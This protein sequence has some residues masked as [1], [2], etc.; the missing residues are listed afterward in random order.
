[1]PQFTGNATVDKNTNIDLL[2]AEIDVV[3]MRTNEAPL[4][5]AQFYNTETRSEGTEW[6]VSSVGSALPL[7]Q[8]NEDT[9]NLPYFTSP[10]GFKTTISKLNFRS[11]IRVTD[12][13]LTLDRQNKTRE[14]TMGQAKSAVRLDEYMRAVAFNNGFATT[15]LADGVYMFSASHPHE[16]AE[17]GTWDNLATGALTGANLQAARLKMEKIDD[18]Q[19]DPMDITP[20]GV[21]ISVDMEQKAL[22]LIKSTKV[23]EDGLNAETQLINSFSIV[24]TKYLTST[25]AFFVFGNMTGYAKGLME[26]VA[27]DWNIKNNSPSNVDIVIDKRIKAIKA[28][29]AMPTKNFVGSTGT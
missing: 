5:L 22:E 16:N 23:A 20:M 19:G 12:T 1:M 15:T 25:T 24:K 10:P 27:Q 9:D 8:I 26:I 6:V 28:F 7:P 14:I 21:L 2:S 3:F 11:G 29:G 18:E 13:M 17:A 4:S